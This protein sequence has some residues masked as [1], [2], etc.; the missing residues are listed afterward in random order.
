MSH[1]EMETRTTSKGNRVEKPRAETDGN[2]A[3]G[4]IPAVGIQPNIPATFRIKMIYPTSPTAI[5]LSDLQSNI[6]FSF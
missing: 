3:D 5:N 6:L 4:Q 2:D 1:K